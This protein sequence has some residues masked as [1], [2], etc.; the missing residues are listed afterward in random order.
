LKSEVVVLGDVTIDIVARVE[1]YPVAGGDVQPL[2]TRLNL[3]GTS[4]NTAMMLARLGI[5]TTLVARIGPDFLGDHVLAQMEANGLSTRCMQRDECQVTGLVY[6]AV[7]PDGQRT[8]LG[9]AGA[10]RGLT[11]SAGAIDA[12]EGACWL[13][14]TSYNVLAPLSLNATLSAI[15]IARSRSVHTSLDIGDAPPRLA[16]EELSLVADQVNYLFPSGGTVATVGPGQTVIRKRGGDGCELIT[17]GE[18][19]SVP[20]FHVDVLDST[21]AG[22]AFD[23]GFIAGQVRGLDLRSSAL[24]ANACGAAACAVLGAGEALPPARIVC[25]LLIS[26]TPAGWANEAR[27]ALPILSKL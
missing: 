3:G 18:T 24:L 2:Q 23:A 27:S 14:V 15:V 20:A 22:D 8:M 19:I 12:V 13:H 9:G 11:L 16:P 5:V 4:L 25:D 7:T 10:N 17:P 26:K 1:S 6:I 21:G